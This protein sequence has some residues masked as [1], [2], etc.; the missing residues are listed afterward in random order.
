MAAGL[1]HRQAGKKRDVGSHP[2]LTRGFSP[3][4]GTRS[5]SS[6]LQN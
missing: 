1:R 4:L 2:G 5:R 6:G 3:A